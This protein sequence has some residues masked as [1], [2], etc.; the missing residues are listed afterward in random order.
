MLSG[1]Y[2]RQAE[3]LVLGTGEKSIAQSVELLQ[4]FIADVIQPEKPSIAL[5]MVPKPLHQRR[6]P[7]PLV[8]GQ[9][10]P[11]FA[12]HND[13]VDVGTARPELRERR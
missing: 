4:A 1:L 9:R 8:I 10:S 11:A 13:E 5:R 6:D 7:S 2:Q 3:A 12:P